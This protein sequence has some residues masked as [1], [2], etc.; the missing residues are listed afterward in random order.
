M[1]THVNPKR[2][3]KMMTKSR[4]ECWPA[5]STPDCAPGS[6][7]YPQLSHSLL[8]YVVRSVVRLATTARSSATESM[9]LHVKIM[10]SAAEV[11]RRAQPAKVPKRNWAGVRRVIY[12]V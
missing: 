10:T 2:L 6:I 7:K 1:S 9:A 5:E 12:V 3:K 11:K 4:N 8:A